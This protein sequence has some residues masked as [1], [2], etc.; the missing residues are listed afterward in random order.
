MPPYEGVFQMVQITDQLAALT[1]SELRA[2]LKLAEVTG[3]NLEKLAELQFNAAKGAYS[4][5]VAALRRLSSM[6]EP[7][8]VAAFA[9]SA[10]RPAWEGATAYARKVYELGVAAQVQVAALVEERVTDFN[11]NMVLTLDAILKSAPAG[12]EGALSG[13]KS[14]VHSANTAYETLVKA[15]RQ[16]A[17]MADASL[18]E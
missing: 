3:E 13:F 9:A 12:S 15:G 16:F 17:S 7:G 10:A 5:G 2:T 14:A 8:E 18:A 4:D 1:K 11:K 6:R